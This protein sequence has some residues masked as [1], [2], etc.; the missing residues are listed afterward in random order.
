MHIVRRRVPLSKDRWQ[1]T[2]AVR[3][4][5]SMVFLASAY[6]KFAHPDVFRDE[7]HRIGW[8]PATVAAA[9]IMALPWLELVCGASAVASLR[10]PLCLLPPTVCCVLFASVAVIGVARNQTGGC[11]CFPGIF[12]FASPGTHLSFALLLC[13]TC[14]WLWRPRTLTAPSAFSDP[15][16]ALRREGQNQFLLLLIAAS[17]LSFVA[18]QSGA[19]SK[20]NEGPGLNSPIAPVLARSAMTPAT[21]TMVMVFDA[22][23]PFCID[24]IQRLESLYRLHPSELAVVV[25]SESSPRETANFFQQGHYTIPFV[26]DLQNQIESS[27]MVEVT[28]YILLYQDGKLR[29]KGAGEDALPKSEQIFFADQ[30]RS[31][32]GR[33]ARSAGG[34]P[35]RL[36]TVFSCR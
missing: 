34:E 24:T 12:Q 30:Q 27:L 9:V 23:C 15:A 28:P 3:L 22:T 21:W 36:Q 25:L 19:D 35:K 17:A 32:D 6:A 10:W 8:L 5:L 18:T 11:G 31:I 20:H 7:V 13:F 26:V 16:E 29:F 1:V 33:N 14:L 4:A 2:D